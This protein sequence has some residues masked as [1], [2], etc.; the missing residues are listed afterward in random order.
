MQTTDLIERLATDLRPLPA[1]AALTRIAVGLLSG[2][3]LALV[4]V[5]WI[6]GTDL[7]VAVFTTAFW[8]KWA[9]GFTLT[10]IALGLCFESTAE[11]SGEFNCGICGCTAWTDEI[12]DKSVTVRGSPEFCAAAA[13]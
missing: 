8:I 13:A 2:G 12:W 10:A 7:S 6:L 4:G 5:V 3:L 11:E 9:Y 1:R